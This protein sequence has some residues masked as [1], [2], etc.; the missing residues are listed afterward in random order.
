MGRGAIPDRRGMDG[1][2]SSEFPPRDRGADVQVTTVVGD[3]LVPSR[4]LG[5]G[6]SD[7][8]DHKGRPYD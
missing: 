7:T 4:C 6:M 1:F 8:G 2:L 5:N 3:G